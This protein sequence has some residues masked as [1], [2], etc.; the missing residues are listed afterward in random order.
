MSVLLEGL[1]YDKSLVERIIKEDTIELNYLWH[2]KG[3]GFQAVIQLSLN[4]RV[5]LK[6]KPVPVFHDPEL[7]HVILARE[8]KSLR[9]YFASID[10]N[11]NYDFKGYY[12]KDERNQQE[13]GSLVEN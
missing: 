7:A 4:D 6:S 13:F 11:R 10:H 5:L 3:D 2:R 9:D 1:E 8:A 12:L